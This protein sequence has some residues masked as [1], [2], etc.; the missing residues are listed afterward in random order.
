MKKNGK[1]NIRV[2]KEFVAI[3]PVTLTQAE[4]NERSHQ[5]ASIGPRLV[6]LRADFERQKKDFRD[7]EARLEAERWRLEEIV[8]EKSEP[9]E[10]PCQ[11]VA[12]LDEHRYKVHRLDTGELVPG[13]SRSLTDADLQRSLGLD[14][15]PEEKALAAPDDYSPVPAKGEGRRKAV[16]P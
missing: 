2:L 1:S 11:A 14:S 8:R 15:E 12:N 10:V 5:L 7:A 13:A 4:F 16:Q 3:L 9:R 6:E